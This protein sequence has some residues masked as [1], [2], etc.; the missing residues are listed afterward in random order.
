[1]WAKEEKDCSGWMDTHIHVY[2]CACL[3]ELLLPPSFYV[4]FASRWPADIFFSSPQHEF[5]MFKNGMCFHKNR[6]FLAHLKELGSLGPP[7]DTVRLHWSYLPASLFKL[8]RCSVVLHSFY[9]SLY[10]LH[11]KVEC[12]SFTIAFELFCV[13]HPSCSNLFLTLT[14]IGPDL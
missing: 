3:C 5:P 9:Q 11:V 1:M 7:S 14:S 2:A 8:R 10:S 13:L 4:V 6:L 12:P